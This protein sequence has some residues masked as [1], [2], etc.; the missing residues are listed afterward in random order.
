L[1]LSTL[2]SDTFNLIPE[3]SLEFPKLIPAFRKGIFKALPFD[4]ES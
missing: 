4:P 1:I 2:L 3:N